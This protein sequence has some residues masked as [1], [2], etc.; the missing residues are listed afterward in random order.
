[1]KVAKKLIYQAE[2]GQGFI[3]K[4]F[5][6]TVATQ[7]SLGYCHLKGFLRLLKLMFMEGQ[8]KCGARVFPS[9]GLTVL[10]LSRMTGHKDLKNLMI[11]FNPDPESIAERL[12]GLQ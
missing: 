11:Y 8:E 7:Q 4:S 5:L 12:Q 1:M 10:D 2:C 6:V 9:I 3:L